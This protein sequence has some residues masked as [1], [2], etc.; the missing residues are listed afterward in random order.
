VTHS[1]RFSYRGSPEWIYRIPFFAA[2][3]TISIR[4]RALNLIRMFNK[5]V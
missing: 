4:F 5:W 1:S 2:I 3:T